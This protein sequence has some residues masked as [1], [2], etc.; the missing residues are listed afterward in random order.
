[1]TLAIIG[2]RWLPRSCPRIPSGQR[3]FSGLIQDWN[4]IRDYQRR[5]D[6]Q[7]TCRLTLAEILAKH[8]EHLGAAHL[9][10][11]VANSGSGCHN[12]RKA[13]KLSTLFNQIGDRQRA[14]QYAQLALDC[15]LKQREL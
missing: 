4:P 9:L 12:W 15:R 7:N 8:G 6:R 11:Q 3:R 13:Y 14:E 5:L 10:Q 1:M 2:V